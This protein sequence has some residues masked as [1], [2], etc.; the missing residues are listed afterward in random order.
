MYKRNSIDPDKKCLIE[1]EIFVNYCVLYEYEGLGMHP[2]DH[3]VVPN[4]PLN[5][6]ERMDV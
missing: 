4:I 1:I 3:N 5:L 6:V 2:L